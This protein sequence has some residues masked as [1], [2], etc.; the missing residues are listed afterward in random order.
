MKQ[1]LLA[2]VLL[3]AGSA[4]GLAMP[5]ELTGFVSGAGDDLSVNL[6]T[7]RIH[8]TGFRN[9]KGV[10]GAA[11]FSSP[12]GWPEQNAK[13]QALDAFPITGTMATLTFKL[14]PGRYAVVVLHD[15]NKN[16]K[17]DRNF[18]GVPTEGFG[19]ANNPPVLLVAPSFE[20]ASIEVACPATD[21]NVKMIYK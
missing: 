8:A 7:L 2:I 21:I 9:D 17:L 10:A 14:P 20:R 6:C 4:F 18:I 3:S 16:Q 11:V 1:L 13:A 15:E 19:F 5:G 12:K